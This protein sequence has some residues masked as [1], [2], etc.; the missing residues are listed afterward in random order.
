MSKTKKLLHNR[1]TTYGKFDTLADTSQQ[2]KEIFYSAVNKNQNNVLFTS[3]ILESVEMI[4]HKIAR[5]ANGDPTYLENF[6]DIAGYAT[7]TESI[8]KEKDGSIDAKV[9]KIIRKNGTW[10]PSKG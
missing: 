7:L 4:L 10:K 9:T 5:I 1:G 6:R 8:L 3:E 2:L